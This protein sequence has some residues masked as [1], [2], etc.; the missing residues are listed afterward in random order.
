MPRKSKPSWTLR[1]AKDVDDKARRMMIEIRR[2]F[3][4]RLVNYDICVLFF[5]EPK[6]DKAGRSVP[7][8]VGIATPREKLYGIADAFLYLAES[9]WK[10]APVELR[11][12]LIAHLLGHLDVTGKGKSSAFWAW[13]V[14]LIKPN[15]STAPLFPS[16]RAA[17]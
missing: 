5:P 12:Y 3:H 16:C 1:L 11:E 2:D 7:G 9:W 17:C 8:A 4:P 15:T 6:T 13:S 10:K 14:P